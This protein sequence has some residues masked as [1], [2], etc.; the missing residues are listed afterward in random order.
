M[1]AKVTNFSI[2]KAYLKWDKNEDMISRKQVC[3]RDR[4][5]LTKC[6]QNENR[7]HDPRLLTRVGYQAAFCIGFNRKLEIWIIKQ[8]RGYHNHHLVDIIDTQFLWS[9]KAICNPDKAQINAMRK[10]GLKTSQIIDYMVQQLG[11]H[12]HIGFTPNDIYNHVDV[13]HRIEW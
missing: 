9:Y 12:E 4:H 6:F 8:L 7:Q 11:G 1:F 3:S 13:M 5:R 2:Q 10:V